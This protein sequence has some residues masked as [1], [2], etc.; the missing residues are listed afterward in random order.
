M[1]E[2]IIDWYCIMTCLNFTPANNCKILNK[3]KMKTQKTNSTNAMTAIIFFVASVI[4]VACANKQ[5]DSI[6]KQG[7]SKASQ[8]NP[9]PPSIDIHA[10]AFMGNLDAIRQHIQA[11][12]DLN[13][14][15]DYG[16]TPLITAAVFGKTEVALALIEAGADLNLKNNDGSTPLHSAA[17]FGRTEIVK[18]LLEN[19]ADKNLKNNFGSTPLE[20]VSASFEDV[21][22]IYDQVSKD[23]GTLGLKLDYKRLE[24]VRP[25]IAELLR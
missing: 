14:K 13:K 23:L 25:E 16:S 5:P 6:R 19:G 21:K 4:L 22:V 2:H 10:A 20:S 15:D 17:F 18:A 8:E 9:K 1:I 24:K 3:K 12:T 7:N 11:G